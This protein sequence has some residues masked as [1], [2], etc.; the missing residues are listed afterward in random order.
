MKGTNISKEQHPKDKTNFMAHFFFLWEIPIVIQYLRQKI[1]DDCFNVPLKKHE[2]AVLGA[3]FEEIWISEESQ[4]RPSL[5]RALGKTFGMR[6][7]LYGILYF[8]ID[9]VIYLGQPFHLNKLLH[10]YDPDQTATAKDVLYHGVI[11]I[12]ISFLGVVII[13]FFFLEFATIGLEMRI[14]CTSL[15]YRKLLQSKKSTLE[16]MTHGRLV[17]L[18]SNHVEKFDRTAIYFHFIWMGCLKAMAMI[19]FIC[20]HFDYITT[21]AIGLFII[22]FLFQTYITRRNFNNRNFIVQKTDSRIRLLNEIICGIRAI[23]LYVWEN[24]FAKW[25]Y[26]ARKQELDA[27]SKAN[28]LRLTVWTFTVY[29]Q[30]IAL[31]ICVLIKTLLG[32]Q[33]SAAYVFTVANITE[34]TRTTLHIL[35]SSL[36]FTTEGIVSLKQIEEFLLSNTYKKRQQEPPVTFSCI[37]ENVFLENCLYNVCLNIAPK[38]LLGLTGVCGSGKTSLLK[39]ILGEVEVKGTIFCQGTISYA[40]QEP[41][42]FSGSLEENV[43][44]GEKFDKERYTK[45]I[46]VCALEHDLSLLPNGENTLVGERGVMLSGGQRA[47]IGLARAVYRNADLYLLDDSLSAVDNLVATHI[48]NNCIRNFLSDKSIIF[49]TTQTSFLKQVDRVCLLSE[50]KVEALGHYNEVEDLV[51]KSVKEIAQPVIQSN[52]TLLEIKE[53]IG[54]TNTSPYKSYFKAG[55]FTRTILLFLF[56]VFVQ[57]QVNSMDCL[58]VFWINLK[59]STFRLNTKIFLFTCGAISISVVV[60]THLSSYALTKYCKRA[61]RCLH[62][63]LFEKLLKG[64]MTFFN[65]HSSGRILNRFSTD[66]GTVDEIVPLSLGEMIRKFLYI[67]GCYIIIIYVNFWMV[68]PT[69]IFISLVALY[70]LLFYPVISR[71]KHFEGLKR[72]PIITQLSASIQGLEIIRAAKAQTFL[73]NKFDEIQNLHSAAFYMHKALYFTFCFWTDFTQFLYTA[74]VICFF[75]LYGNGNV[76]LAI[77]QSL[78]FIGLTQYILK[79]WANLNSEM[80]SVQRIVEYSDLAL[81]ADE[82]FLT[83]P[84]VWPEKGNIQFNSVSMRYSSNAPLVLKNINLHVEGGSKIGIVG[85]TGSGKSS[86]IS[87]LFRLFPFEGSIRIDGID[88]KFL[89]LNILRSNI[90]IIP[91]EPI[92]FCG[93]I[94]KNLDPFNEFDNPHL[95]SALEEVQLKNV[96]RNLDSEINLSVGQKQLLCL[97]R[98]VLKKSKIIALDEATSSVDVETDHL[99]QSTIRRRFQ[100]STVLTI[101]HRLDT[102]MDCDRILVLESGRMVEYG[103]TEELLKNSEGYFYKYVHAS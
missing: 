103:K 84:G 47:R 41:W 39:T 100:D 34:L 36:I 88:T 82:G 23:K 64:S 95:W 14:A 65:N 75:V 56:F 1:T 20:V 83:P 54:N 44:F 45:V 29:V 73:Q 53:N 21:T 38:E 80:V 79:M 28:F 57:V 97:A 15:I 92:L 69:I 63:A 8:C 18:L 19:I 42:I 40:P 62:N 78:I 4:K 32:F 25:M 94:R 5:I 16:K 66:V 24:V 3:K 93:S 13:H 101:A 31:Y 74:V 35:S 30:K 72:S 70:V 58:L 77:T 102:V 9:L 27:I 48:F 61:S 37:L 55:G 46:Q 85:R 68:I 52:D 96:V 6:Y 87:I 71:V 43:L 59:E 7:I 99:I 33:I 2:A 98:A 91:Q 17:N 12:L 51:D 49:V 10:C 60:S 22:A 26:T 67:L 76:G 90:A 89:P 81:E 50:G 86:L 11:I